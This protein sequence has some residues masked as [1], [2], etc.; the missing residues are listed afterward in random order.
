MTP[1]A[2]LT[3]AR[4]ATRQRSCVLFLASR[5]ATLAGVGLV[6]GPG[7]SNSLWV[8]GREDFKPVRQISGPDGLMFPD[9][10]AI[11]LSEDG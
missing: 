8:V 5:L 6:D 2:L 3:Q 7:L 11:G 9:K 1:R 10:T 4:P